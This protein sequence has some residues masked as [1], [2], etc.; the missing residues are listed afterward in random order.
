MAKMLRAAK[1]ALNM[2]SYGCERNGPIWRW[3]QYAD[4]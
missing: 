1:M 4:Y 2:R 3:V